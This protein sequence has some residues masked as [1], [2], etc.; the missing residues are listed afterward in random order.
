VARDTIEEGLYNLSLR[1]NEWSDKLL[2]DEEAAVEEFIT[3]K[4]RKLLY[5]QGRKQ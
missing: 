1:R 2:G 4:D 5:K 3:A